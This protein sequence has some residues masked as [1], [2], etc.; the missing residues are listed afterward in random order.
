MWI[1]YVIKLALPSTKHWIRS[2][3][4]QLNVKHRNH[5]KIP[6]CNTWCPSFVKIPKIYLLRIKFERNVRCWRIFFIIRRLWKLT[7]QQKLGKWRKNF[8]LLKITL[9]I[10]H[11]LKSIFKDFKQNFSERVL[12]LPPELASPENFDYLKDSPIAVNQEPPTLEEI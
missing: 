8:N 6:S 10:N 2:V 12:Q 3:P 1:H 11:L 4:S 5:G 9:C 7:V